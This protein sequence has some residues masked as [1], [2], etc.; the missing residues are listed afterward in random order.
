[1]TSPDYARRTD[2]RYHSL[3]VPPD[4]EWSALRRLPGLELDRLGSRLAYCCRMDRAWTVM[5]HRQGLVDT[6]LA[7]RVLQALVLTGDERGWGGEDWL[8]ERLGGDEHAASVINYGRTLQEPMARMQMRDAL[9]NVFDDL[10]ACREGI[11]AA[12]ETYADALMA[13]QSH[14]SHAQPTT[15]GAYL[16]AVHDGLARAEAQLDL[17]YRHTN[18]NS[19][20][21]GACS[22]TGWPV[23]RELVTRLLGFDDT[24]ESA[25]DC[26]GS[27]DEIPQILFALS[28]LALT[29]DRS[30]LDHSVWSLEEV[31]S[32]RLAPPWRGVS[33]F[34]PQKAHAGR[35]ENVREA[36]VAVMGQMM[37]AVLT[38]KNEPIQDVL[39]VYHAPVC[40]LNGCAHAR[41]LLQLWTRL[42]ENLEVNRDRMREI[43]RAGY[44]GAPDLAIVLIR[45]RRFAG[46]QAH[47]VCATCVR[48]ARERGVRP[49]DLDGALLDEAARLTG[50]PEPG[51]PD[52]RVREIM[53]LDRF[54]DLHDNLG[55]PHPRETRRLVARRREALGADRERQ[56]GRRDRLAAGH[57]LLEAEEA[58]ILGAPA[59]EPG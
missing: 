51:L 33:S 39:P 31:G 25:Y 44:S 22:G 6:A 41:K 15:Y 13:G 30:A 1:M 42:L 28:S 56:A 10:H 26:E 16:V 11:L 29:L 43:V 14:F 49:A 18:L 5:L 54:L 38:F 40:A 52:A 50:D 8:K 58:A 55:D 48:I 35:F 19:G 24:L 57:R 45:E 7:R 27:Q 37:T 23:D 21:C 9:L 59:P 4:S 3:G 20:G 34:M 36:A 2:H 47:R 53:G 17:A 46:R 12:A 32:I